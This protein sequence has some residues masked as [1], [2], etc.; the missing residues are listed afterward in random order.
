MITDV[1]ALIIFGYL[2]C[3]L[4][5][6]LHGVRNLVVVYLFAIVCIWPPLA[7]FHK[8]SD[9]LSYAVQIVSVAS[10][11]VSSCVI[12]REIRLRRRAVPG[13]RR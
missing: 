2:M 5:G 10:I 6:I 11:I 7:I 12:V 13:N 4:A 9:G 8:Y 1:E 3:V